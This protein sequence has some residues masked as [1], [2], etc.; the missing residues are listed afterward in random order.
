MGEAVQ[1]RLRELAPRIPAGMELGVVS[2]Q[3]EDVTK[4]IDGFVVNLA[5]ALAIVIAVLWVFMGWRS[6]V[7]IGLSLL[8]TIIGTFVLTSAGA[9]TQYLVTSSDSGPVAGSDVTMT[10]QL[11]DVNGNAVSTSGLIVSYPIFVPS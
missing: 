10:A 7:L 3:A 11:A 1:E 9:A 6:A 4:A 2:F 8:I 5:E